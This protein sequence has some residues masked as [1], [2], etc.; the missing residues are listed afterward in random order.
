M[1]IYLKRI[2]KKNHRVSCS[3]FEILKIYNHTKLYIENLI[4]KEQGKHIEYRIH[5]RRGSG[6][7]E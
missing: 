6:F 3:K 1:K 5:Y 7:V 4:F 2:A